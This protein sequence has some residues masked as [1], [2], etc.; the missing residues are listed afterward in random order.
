MNAPVLWRGLGVSEG[1]E[2]VHG[3]G[4]TGDVSVGF[5]VMDIKVFKMA[6]GRVVFLTGG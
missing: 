4:G 6:R 2:E 3:A 1:V 5:V